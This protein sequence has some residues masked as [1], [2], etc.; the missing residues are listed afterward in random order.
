MRITHLRFA[1]LNALVGEWTIDF[2]D[3]A[4]LDDGIF[5]I[6]GPTGSGKTTILDAI[7]LALYGSTPRLGRIT[8]SQNE[9]MSRRQG[10]CFAEVK[11]DTAKGSYCCHWGQHRSRHQPDGAL[12][13]AK[14]EIA[15]ATTG[16]VIASKLKEVEKQ[17][18]DLTGM[19]FEQFTRSMLLAQGSFAAFLQASP[20]ER[21]PILEKITGTGIY[22]E[23]SK[24]VYL[25]QKEHKQALDDLKKDLAYTDI[26]TPEQ[27]QHCEAEYTEQ[28]LRCQNLEHLQQQREQRLQHYRAYM[29]LQTQAETV[30]SESDALAAAQQAFAPDA[31][32][33]QTH[34]RT[35]PLRERFQ[36]LHHLQT[37]HHQTQA[38]LT[39]LQAKLPAA[40]QAYA[41]TQTEFQQ[42]KAAL[43]DQEVQWEQDTQTWEQ[44]RALD[45]AC[46]HQAEAL[47]QQKLRLTQEQSAHEALVKE[48]A[49]NAEQR[50]SLTTQ[51]QA[52]KEKLDQ[53]A[54]HQQLVEEMS[55]FREW[56]KSLTQDQAAYQQTHAH[57]QGVQQRQSEQKQ[58][59]NERALQLAAEAEAKA[60]SQQHI[61]ALGA[62]LKTY[63][64]VSELKDQWENYS[65]QLSTVAQAQQVVAQ[66]QEAQKAWV[67]CQTQLQEGTRQAEHDATQQLEKQAALA[68]TTQEMQL[69]QRQ[70]ELEQRIEKLED[71][72]KKLIAGDPCP[73]CGATEHPLGHAEIQPDQTQNQLNQLQQAAEQLQSE[74]HQLTALGTTWQKQASL[75]QT[76]ALTLEQKIADLQEQ[77]SL[78]PA[79]IQQNLDA[80]FDANATPEAWELQLRKAVETLTLARD[81]IT[82]Q[83]RDREQVEKDYQQALADHQ[84]RIERLETQ[85]DTDRAQT[86]TLERLGQEVLYDT[87]Q[88]AQLSR[89]MDEHLA[90]LKQQW[91]RCMGTENGFPDLK[92]HAEGD[93]DQ[94]LTTQDM[95]QLQHMLSTLEEHKN[96]W[97]KHHQDQQ[98]LQQALALNQQQQ[99]N[100]DLQ[101]AQATVR[102]TQAETK[103]QALSDEQVA[104][105]TERQ[106]RF[107]ERSA[108]QEEAQ[109]RELLGNA[110]NAVQVAELAY[111]NAREQ[112]ITDQQQAETAQKR[113]QEEQ[114]QLLSLQ[115]AFEKELDVSG[116]ATEQDFQA[117]ILSTEVREA[118]EAQQKQ[119]AAESTRLETRQQSL[120]EQFTKLQDTR[121]SDEFTPI[122]NDAELG[123]VEGLYAKVRID[124]QEAL[125]QQGVLQDQLAQ[126]KKAHQQQAEQ[127]Q[128]LQQLQATYAHW[129]VMYDLI[130]ASDGKR[131]RDFAQGLTFDDRDASFETFAC[132]ATTQSFPAAL[133]DPKM[134]R[135]LRSVHKLPP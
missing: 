47:E 114:L 34:Q 9:I 10:E 96:Q 107:G 72:R 118:V 77:L 111:Q 36:A 16:K 99:G 73:L 11:F 55:R 17:V 15:D 134:P 28:V 24:A 37:R 135:G 41:T 45:T 46:A 54:H 52:L 104:L 51:Y 49:Q 86:Q 102:Y 12:Q 128:R 74:V 14:H 121:R 63:P 44:M 31:E 76:E 103:R 129:K 93:D 13:A 113:Q 131:Y 90:N 30:A 4:F 21:S 117:A 130:G 75:L 20:S 65:T 25:Q 57:L 126:D 42:R 115:T 68:Q 59:Q 78:V 84:Q 18:Q 133:D 88:L 127:L 83:L 3:P 6:T 119:L 33:L 32:R 71:Y 22:T 56:V 62:Q 79:T 64:V 108:L 40:E 19:D 8:A 85:A 87:D 112:Y 50:V 43:T 7:C 105:Q 82:T 61:N 23:I 125:K 92:K 35:E 1:N 124:L 69:V 70:R 80:D 116:F 81:A 66:W 53:S 120:K 97:Q 27:K 110:R 26:M 109:S 94:A 38:Q 95:T 132:Y 100:L 48:V 5:A 60:Q 58:L 106:R 39:A 67:R 98:K 122:Q 91:L 29:E 101:L 2:N 123:E 89:R